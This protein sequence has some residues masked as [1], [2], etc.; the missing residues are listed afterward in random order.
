MDAVQ[1]AAAEA[2]FLKL[3]KP[4]Y[5]TFSRQIPSLLH[6]IHLDFWGKSV[7]PVQELIYHSAYTNPLQPITLCCYRGRALIEL[8]A[9][10]T[11]QAGPD[12]G[13]LMQVMSGPSSGL[14]V[15]YFSVS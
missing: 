8:G 3:F 1:V 11:N 6:L 7:T 14:S 9:G 13:I 12:G 2:A 5:G 10:S 15:S 4:F